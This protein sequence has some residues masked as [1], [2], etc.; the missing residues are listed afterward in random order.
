MDGPLSYR[1]LPDSDGDGWRWQLVCGA[2][3]ILEGIAATHAAA[4]AEVA[5]IVLSLQASALH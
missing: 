5:E 3:V 1:A 4:V 2:V